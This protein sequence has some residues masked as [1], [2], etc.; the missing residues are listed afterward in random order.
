MFLSVIDSLPTTSYIKMVEV[1]L[2]FSLLIPFLEVLILSLIHHKSSSGPKYT[3]TR[4][5]PTEEDPNKD[6]SGKNLKEIY[7][8]RLAIIL[9]DYGIPLMFL[10][11][12]IVYWAIGLAVS[13]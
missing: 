1:W 13:Q 5:G 7:L 6:E 11:F 4:V 2:I 12:T 9:R 8:L 10:M 3:D